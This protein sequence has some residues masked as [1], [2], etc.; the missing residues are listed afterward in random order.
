MRATDSPHPP[1]PSPSPTPT[2]GDIDDVLAQT[3]APLEVPTDAGRRVEV[4]AGPVRGMLAASL[5]ISAS[6]D[7]WG[8]ARDEL[9][10]RLIRG[11]DGRPR[12]QMRVELGVIQ[13]ETEG[14]P[15]GLTVGGGGGGGGG[16]FATQLA[17]TRDR[18]IR[19]RRRHRS[20]FGF[21]L[22]ADEIVVLEHEGRLFARRYLAWF[23]LGEWQRV[24]SDSRHHLSILGLLR[25]HAQGN[26]E[27]QSAMFRWLPYAAMMLARAEAASAM[28]GGDN[29][30]ATKIVHSAQ[31]RLKRHY[32][33]HGGA[34]AYA[35][36]SEVR[37]LKTVAR[38]L[39]RHS[40]ES[41]LRRLKRLL[42]IAV[43][44]EQYEKAAQLRDRIQALG[45]RF[46]R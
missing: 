30:L 26:A 15:D 37:A 31:R 16:G 18:L 14:R 4:D 25:D 3:G 9:T 29:R 27:A 42:R 7:G 10:A 34:G 6:I 33:T 11:D 1:T 38:Q 40:P 41:P 24:I 39:H 21:E 17:I 36:S 2:P 28:S 35:T 32:R 46:C 20:D 43:E 12:L 45:G 5:D 44:R 13:M 23:V 19:Y 22:D 8:C